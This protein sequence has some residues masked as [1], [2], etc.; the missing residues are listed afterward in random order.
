MTQVS[1][2]TFV[3]FPAVGSTMSL[4][5][6]ADRLLQNQKT[7]WSQLRDGYASLRS[8]Q[9]RTVECVGFSVVLQFNPARIVS[10]GAK[11][12]ER[13]IRE[14]RCFLCLQNLPE[15]QKGV[16]FQEH[17]LILCNPA[18]IF[19]HHFT[20]AH[21]DHREQVIEG[22]VGTLLDLARDLHG[23]TVF[24]NGPRC[25]ASAPDH[26]HFQA[27]PSGII[28]VERD[29]AGTEYRSSHKTQSNVSIW[30]MKDYGRQVIVLESAHQNELESVFLQLIAAMKSVLKQ[31]DEPMINVLCFFKEGRW[32]IIVFPRSKHRPDVY[33]KEGPE[34][35]LIS[36]AAADV[37]GFIVTPVEKDYR[38][39]DAGLVESIFREVSLDRPAV[40]QI[41][42]AL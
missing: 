15:A 7:S 10:T 8:A 5:D 19:D 20:I 42:S 32:T 26:L 27:C 35:I 40:D 6:H 25:G 24:Y 3:R 39:T 22:S 23:Y 33:F 41:L 28:P 37:G 11:V 17:F 21:T 4:T 2:K 14:R 30:S 1:D 16:L 38:V 34:R 29:S 13:S 18:P 12:D 9:T 31:S 36:P